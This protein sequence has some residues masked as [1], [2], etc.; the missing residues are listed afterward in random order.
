MEWKP[1]ETVEPWAR[2]LV[3]RPDITPDKQVFEALATPDGGYSD[4]VYAEWDGFGA[5]H[6][7]PLPAPP[8]SKE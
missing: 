5:T 8:H 4:P 1:I 6:W 7:M 3:Y 2:V